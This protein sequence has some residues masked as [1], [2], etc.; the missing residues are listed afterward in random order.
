[1]TN[2]AKTEYH[3]LSA[4]GPE[5]P[6]REVFV[7]LAYLDDA[8]T[9]EHS[10]IVV[11]GAVIVFPQSFGTLENLHGA[12]IQQI[13]AVNDIEK[14]FN[15][16]KASELYNGE[17]PFKGIDQKQR[18]EAIWVLLTA[19]KT[20]KFPYIYAAVERKKLRSSPM[21]S[22]KPFDVAFNLCALGI[23][24][25]AQNMHPH[26]PGCIKLDLND[27]YLFIMDDTEDKLLKDQLRSSYRSIRA[28]RPYITPE[29]NRLWHAHDDMYFGDS[30]ASVGIQ[31]VD[32]CN[33]FMWRHLV[34]KEDEEGFY[35][36]FSEQAVCAKPEPEWAMYGELFRSHDGNK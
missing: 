4:H 31:M 24:D 34:G 26:D 13:I 27:L 23:E 1:M 2:Q 30:R 12:A 28:A 6:A 29:K 20:E 9:D 8:G 18:F 3:A 15:E 32:L 25:W 11:C 22:A 16:F 33:Y 10:P 35:E 17:G 19:L 7:H 36:M 14:N 21:R 5:R